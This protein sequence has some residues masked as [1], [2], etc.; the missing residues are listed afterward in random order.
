MHSTRETLVKTVQDFVAERLRQDY[1]IL[2]AYLCGSLLAEEF[3]LGGMADIDLFFVCLEE[4]AL[5][6]EIRQ[7]TEN[8]HLDIA[9]LGQ[10]EFRHARQLRVHPWL[11]P[12]LKE[13]RVVHDPQHFLDF[14]IAGVR[15]QYERADHTYARASQLAGRARRMATELQDSRAPSSP[16]NL[17]LYLRAVAHCANAIA[18]LSG[19]PLTER[20][21][22]QQF[23]ARAAAV[24]HPGLYPGLLGL[25]G[26]FRLEVA[27]LAV[28]IEDWQAA[29]LATGQVQGSAGTPLARLHPL[30][31]RYYQGAFESL[32]NSPQPENLLWPLLN[33]WTLAVNVL[34]G[35]TDHHQKWEEALTDL[36]LAGPAFSERQAALQAYLDNVEETLRDWKRQNGVS[37]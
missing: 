34:E 29:F 6:R 5:K 26:A 37:E 30:R 7:L 32:L 17:Q 13:A 33:T 22:L 28:W 1:Q 12:A 4:P 21:L 31:R 35:E 16:A 25:L 18:L 19:P 10:R 24:S 23:P 2:A 11:G 3:L 8:L 36:E 9:F 27:C 14:T 20:R 15:G